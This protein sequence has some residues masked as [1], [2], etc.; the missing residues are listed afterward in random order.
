MKDY[1]AILGVSKDATQEEIKRAYRRLALEYHP[2]K[3]PGNKEVEERFKEINEAYAVLSDPEKRAAYDRGQ[4]VQEFSWDDLFD[5]FHQVFGTRPGRAPRG[6]DLEAEV[7]LELVDLLRGKEVEVSYTR[8]VPCPD[9]GGEG[10]KSMVCPSCGGR[11]VVETYRQGFWGTFVSRSTC[12]HCRG[13]GYVLKEVCGTCGGRGR[14]PRKETLKVQIPPGMDERSLLRVP[15]MGH[16][17][18]GGPGDLYLRIRV[19]PHPVLEREGPHLIYR[20]KLGLA[21][22]ALGTRVEI[23]GLEGPIPL[24]IPPG[25]GSGEVFQLEGA[26]LPLPKGGRGHLRVIT[27]LEVPKKLSPKAKALLRAYAEE[28]GEEALPEGFWE[29]LRRGF[30]K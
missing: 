13:R 9:C 26:G 10:G 11:G 25:T 7:E 17:A 29:R 30:K 2:D 3:H 24:E 21:Q 5:L 8:L 1:Y 20:L 19:R 15:G 28:V 14:I 12:P 27:E 22:A 6:E 4:A 23:P 16:L 18:P